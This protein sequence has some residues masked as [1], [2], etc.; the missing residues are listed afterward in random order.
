MAGAAIPRH[1]PTVRGIAH[2]IQFLIDMVR[3]E[4]VP[5]RRRTRNTIRMTVI[6]TLGAGLMTACHVE[7][8]LGTYVLWT[9]IGSP[10]AMMSFAQALGYTVA[11]GILLALSVPLAGILA[12]TPW[13]MLPFI[14]ITMAVLTY[15]V[16]T[17]RFGSAGLVLK[18]VVLDTLYDVVFHQ[19]DFATSTASTFGGTALA[20]LIVALFDTW[21][22]PNPAEVI[23][24]ESLSGSLE[25]IRTRFLEV[26]NIYLDPRRDRIPPEP[27]SFS[28]MARHLDLLDRVAAEGASA[29][30]HGVLLAAI[31]RTERLHGEVDRMTITARE[32]VARGVREMVHKEVTDAIAAIAA[33]ID[34]LA[35]LMPR[36]IPIGPDLP[37][38]PAG[39]LVKPTMEKLDNAT[40]AVRPVYIARAT[41]DEV[42]NFGAFVASLVRMAELV[43]RRLDQPHQSDLK[44][45]RGGWF[46]A[47]HYDPSMAHYSIKLGLATVLGYVVGVTSHHDALGVILTTIIITGLPTYGAIVHKMI[48]RFVGSAIGGVLALLAIILITP[49][50]ETLPVYMLA[51][52]IVF[53]ISGYSGLSSGR[54][55]YAG[56]QIA[57]AFIL[58]FAGL[59]PTEA[60]DGPLY[61][62]F[63][64][65]IGVVVVGAVFFTIWPE[66]SSDSLLPRLRKAFSDTLDLIPVTAVS[67]SGP[68]IDATSKDITHTLFELLNVVDDARL[69]GSR[70]RVDAGAVV[71]ACGTLRRIAHRF[72]R[73]D[74]ERIA[75]PLPPLSEESA[76][77]Y[78]RF[79][80][81]LRARL[82]AWLDLLTSRDALNARAAVALAGSFQSDALMEPL[83]EL[84]ARISANQ[85]AEVSAWPIEQRRVL[86]AELQSFHRVTELTAELD[87]HLAHVPQGV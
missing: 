63:G 23:L 84:N 39:A 30:R 87:Q 55:A 66:Y 19:H 41:G 49:N 77:L 20:F 48:L 31:S 71:D 61:R 60:I 57:T 53:A 42:V 65:L 26:T 40:M 86:L 25:K 85:F 58:T 51:L 2:R 28:D 78:A 6:G 70:S 74:A 64:I 69:E 5:H 17:R 47:M 34:E 68:G 11:T 38:P 43:G 50:F 27:P 36:E 81:A 67:G 79:V 59:R 83:R 56:K 10:G 4:M 75:R 24:L 21:L 76:A 14:G 45:R 7:S 73:M 33:A 32:D 35:G 52:A 16:T 72:G 62:V 29:F 22:W 1:L 15:F 9:L 44:A 8:V 37:P 82:T 3:A 54:I 46:D 18:V 80:G 13:L 12:E